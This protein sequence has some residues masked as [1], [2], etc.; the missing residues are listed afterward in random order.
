A[1]AVEMP[2]A[3]V[4]LVRQLLSGVAR[5]KGQFGVAA[6]ADVLAGVSNERSQRWQ[7]EQL[8]VFGLLR[9]YPTKR[10][11]AMLHRVIESGLARQR[12]VG[13]DRPMYVVD[14]TSAGVAVMK[15]DQLPPASLADILPRAGSRQIGTNP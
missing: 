7:L 10:L 1:P 5:L 15:G 4:T 14:L 6:I 11:I 13:G 12:N 9:I 2:Q 3:A 8:S